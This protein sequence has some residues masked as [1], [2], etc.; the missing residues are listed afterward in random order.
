MRQTI[1]GALFRIVSHRAT[2]SL[3]LVSLEVGL[4]QFAQRQRLLRRLVRFNRRDRELGWVVLARRI[5]AVVALHDTLQRLKFGS[6]QSS[7][8]LSTLAATRQSNY[9]SAS[10]IALERIPQDA[11]NLVTGQLAGQHGAEVRDISIVD[12]D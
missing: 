6:S 7:G 3:G 2:A 8:R 12:P 4:K 9:A 5:C 1:D 11:F 10:S